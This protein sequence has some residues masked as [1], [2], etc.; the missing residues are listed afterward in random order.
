MS[1][2][3]AEQATHNHFVLDRGGKVFK[4]TA[5]VIKL[6]ENTTEEAHLELLGVLNSSTACFWLRQRCG[7]KGG[8]GIGR[9]IQPELW[10]ERYN[11]NSTNVEQFP[12]PDLL[13]FERA[14]RLDALAGELQRVTPAGVAALGVPTRA[15]LDAAHVAWKRIRGEMISVQ[16]ELDWEVYGLYG[17]LS[18]NADSLVSDGS[19]P[20]LRLG[21]R[22]FEIALAQKRAN[23]EAGT[24]WFNRH[25]SIPITE[26]PAHWHAKYR[27]LVQQRLAKIESDTYLQ[28]IERPECKRRWITDTWEQMEREALRDWLCDR[29]EDRAFW[30][31]PDP[32]LRSVA[33]LA[34]TLR[35]DADFV[36]IARLYM[37]D[38]DLTDV[39]TELVR[40]QHVPFLAGLRYTDSGIRIRIRREWERAWE[41]QRQEDA[42]MKVGNIQVPSKYKQGDFREQA[43]WRSRGKL[44][45]PKERFIS[46]PECSRDGTLL[47][48]WAGWDYLQ[49][50][51][52]LAAYIGER[53]ELD[54]WDTGRVTPLLAGLAELLPWLRQWHG[55]IDP[56]FG[57]SPADAY[58]GFLDQ[59]LLSL[60]LTSDDLTAWKPQ[61]P[62]RGRRVVRKAAP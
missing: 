41:L 29:L 49:Q 57:Q 53:R 56:A 39:V 24:E 28:L 62:A 43:Y 27:T 23:G 7:P 36:V 8:S 25:R 55:K 22:A 52:A 1:I 37:R 45:V 2:A 38:A 60:R 59:Q 6:P 21:E 13:P 20:P 26:L 61:P 50:A 47:L 19:A 30:F 14:F 33:Q 5:P 12:L 48:G 58:A 54:A 31:R 15:A 10:M 18:D 46:Y 11:F 40:D 4:Q 34:D 17:M 32:G 16:E 42:G 44:D 51:E 3:F 9:G 35:A